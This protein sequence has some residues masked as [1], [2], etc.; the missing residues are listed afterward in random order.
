[1]TK[2]SVAII[3]KNRLA[4]ELLAQARENN[5]D[6]AQLNDATAVAP[7][8]NFVIDTECGAEDK[9]RALLQRLDASLSPSSIILSSCLRFATTLIAS[10]VKKPERI[11]G[12]ATFF[13]LKERRLENDGTIDHPNRATFQISRQRH[14]AGEGWRRSDVSAYFELDYQ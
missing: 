2:S 11:V 7:A 1:M 13:P 4:D 10:W 14:C 12:F 6:A 8:T 9:K 5:L 3:G